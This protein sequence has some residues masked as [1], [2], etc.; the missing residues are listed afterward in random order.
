MMTLR[1][2]ALA[3]AVAATL[4]GCAVGPDYKRPDSTLPGEYKEAPTAGDTTTPVAA[5]VAVDW[6]KSFNDPQLDTLVEQALKDSYDIRIALARVDQAEALVRQANAAL[7]PEVDVN[8]AATRSKTSPLGPNG[9]RAG[10]GNDFR[11]NVATVSYELDFWGKYRRTREAAIA[12][13]QGSRYAHDTVRLSVAGAVAATYISLRS[14]EAQIVATQA[15]LETRDSALKIAQRRYDSGSTSRLDVEQA[16]TQRA[17]AAAQLSRLTQSRDLFANQLALLVGV[18]DLTVPEGK[19]LELPIPQTP[20]V[21]L[22]SSLLD[23]RPDV[24]QAEQQLVSTNAR[25]GVAK[26]ALYPS[27]SLTGLLGVES[28]DLSNL[29]KSGAQVWSAGAALNLPIFDAGRRFAAV[30]QS[31]AVQREALETYRKTAETAYREVRDALVTLRQTAITEEHLTQALRSAQNAERISR[32]RYE[33]GSAAFLELLD[34]Q[35]SVNDARILALTARE[36]RL[37]ASISLYK[38]LGGGW[39][40]PEKQVASS[41]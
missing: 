16:S 23:L 13:A 29:F 7:F 40:N 33:A 19:L 28:V 11:L 8:G 4:A 22:P 24:A 34:A 14:A 5:P 10:I 17:T 31:E 32:A 12:L 36:N 9:A 27:I 20:P 25:I 35:R 18:P 3:A 6:W 30:D 38:A 41:K 2:T 15:S 1:L 37:N 39:V 26:A 21:G